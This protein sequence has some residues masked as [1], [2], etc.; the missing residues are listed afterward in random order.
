MYYS[1]FGQDRWL[2][3]FIFKG[4][5]EGTFVEVGAFDGIFHSNTYFFEKERNWSGICIEANPVLFAD[6]VS[7][8]K[9]RCVNCAVSDVTDELD[10]VQIDGVLRGWSGLAQYM[11]VEHLERIEIRELDKRIIK[12]VSLP[13]HMVI[14]NVHIDYLSID[15]EGSESAIVSSFPFHKFNIDVLEVEDNF[16][17]GIHELVLSKGFSFLKRLGV[18][19]IYRRTGHG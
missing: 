10:F 16:C 8:R 13:L 5:T 12:V 11:E 7:N 17:T 6:L 1:E 4:K 14:D 3:E 9:S 15:V 18:S 19:N 2:D